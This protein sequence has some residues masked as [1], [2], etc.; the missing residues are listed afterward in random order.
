MHCLKPGQ[1]SYGLDDRRSDFGSSLAGILFCIPLRMALG[2][3]QPRVYCVSVFSPHRAK[4]SGGGAEFDYTF[5][6]SDDVNAWRC[7]STPM[8][9]HCLMLKVPGQIFKVT[10]ILCSC[11]LHTSPISKYRPKLCA[12]FGNKNTV[13][14]DRFTLPTCGTHLQYLFGFSA[15]FT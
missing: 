5:P 3:V 6:F 12:V 4:R 9:A 10:H 1:L 13:Y 8:C 14:Q 11:R 2:S 7:A 15:T